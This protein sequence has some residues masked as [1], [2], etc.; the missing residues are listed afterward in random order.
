M[1]FEDLTNKEMI[2]IIIANPSILKRPII[3]D[4]SKMKIGF[5]EDEIS[6]FVPLELR[7]RIILAKKG[8]PIIYAYAPRKYQVGY[9]EETDED[10]DI[11]EE[12]EDAE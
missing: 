1:D 3:M 8:D 10:E 9:C 11:D 2:D 6:L 7:Q 4:G 5:H 12:K